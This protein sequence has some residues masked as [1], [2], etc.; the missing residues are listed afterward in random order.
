MRNM[1]GLIGAA[2]SGG[3]SSL[4]V[5]EELAADTE[6]CH[7]F[8]SGEARAGL[9]SSLRRWRSCVD[10]SCGDDERG[11]ERTRGEDIIAVIDAGDADPGTGTGDEDGGELIGGSETEV[12]LDD[13]PS[14]FDFLKRLRSDSFEFSFRGGVASAPVPA[15]L[16][17][18]DVFGS[19][20]RWGC[21]S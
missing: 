20:G 3:I 14:T 1:P 17:R 9:V 19:E 6:R 10:V 7:G 12:T 18:R 21:S 16:G 8:K 5:D 15:D 2:G 11:V 4:G 13:E